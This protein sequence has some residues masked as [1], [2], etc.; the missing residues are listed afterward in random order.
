VEQLDQAIDVS[1]ATIKMLIIPI[2]AIVIIIDTIV[3][4][5][6][7]PMLAPCIATTIIACVVFALCD[8]EKV[9]GGKL[10]KATSLLL[11]SMNMLCLGILATIFVH[12]NG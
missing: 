8:L 7:T 2:F 9:F 10:N 6:D 11:P 5:V 3:G 1:I 12:V 4:V